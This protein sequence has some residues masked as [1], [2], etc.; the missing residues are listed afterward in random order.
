MGTMALYT[1]D[2]QREYPRRHMPKPEPGSG[3]WGEA[4]NYWLRQRGNWSQADLV[5]AIVERSQHLPKGEQKAGNKNTV[6]AAALGRDVSTQTLRAVARGLDV[7]LEF[8]LV[9]PDRKSAIEEM[10]KVAADVAEEVLLRL[11]ERDH[12]A[13]FTQSNAETIARVHR[14]EAAQ[15]TTAK[16]PPRIIK[17]RRRR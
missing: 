12:Q 13:D 17:H 4:I 2:A 15:R 8:V 7:P 9:S 10:R 11:K 6:S 16:K 3:P 5:R 14:M 1:E